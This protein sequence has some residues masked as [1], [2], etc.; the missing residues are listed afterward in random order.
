MSSP[1]EGPP[2]GN[3]PPDADPPP[4]GVPPDGRRREARI[5]VLYTDIDGTLVGPMGSLFAASDG[6]HT[7]SAASAIFQ[8][9]R[10]GL[11][12]VALSGRSRFGLDEVSRI[13]GLST[14]FGELGAVRVYE[15]GRTIVTDPGRFPGP[16]TAAEA[17]VPAMRGLVDR[18]GPLLEE[19]APWNRG[20]DHSVM[21]RGEAPYAAVR[22]WLDEHGFEWAEYAENGHI[23]KQAHTVPGFEHVRVWHLN[24][25]G[26]SKRAAIAAD[27]AYRGLALEETAMIGDAV[28]DF[29]CWPEVG[30]CFVMRNGIEHDPTLAALVARAQAGGARVEI[31]D[32]GHTE[33]YAETVERLLAC[34]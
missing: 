2:S 6:S 21:V 28:S 4:D 3:P 12:I 29:E 20:R 8:A 16:G 9:H 19:H 15:A 10:S 24:P 13:L 25:L 11:E 18:F 32:R 5:R 17:L 26:I 1:P 22:A 23:P 34:R 31:T 30:R 14:W 27:R 33:G 7:L